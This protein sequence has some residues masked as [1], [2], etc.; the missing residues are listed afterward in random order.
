MKTY[1]FQKAR[2][3][4]EAGKENEMNYNLVFRTIVPKGENTRIALSASN[5]YQMFVNGKM[6]AEGPAR[7][8]HGYYRV[9][10]LDITGYLDQEENIIAIYVDGVFFGTCNCKA[11][12][13][14]P[15]WWQN[16][17][18][19]FFCYFVDY[20]D[21]YKT[22][23]AISTMFAVVFHCSH[24]DKNGKAICFC[25]FKL[26]WKSHCHIYFH[27]LFLLKV[28]LF[29]CKVASSGLIQYQVVSTS[30]EVPLRLWCIPY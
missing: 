6:T 15:D 17:G 9:D 19:N 28:L 12:N 10:E 21:G 29:F 25:F 26:F 8:G 20:S 2:P 14:V 5:M 22:V 4:W 27:I 18:I 11:C 13:P 30:N 23:T 3:V 24:G 1:T 16:N 7:A